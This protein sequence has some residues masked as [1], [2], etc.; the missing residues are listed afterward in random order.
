LGALHHLYQRPHA[1]AQAHVL[2]LWKRTP[3]GIGLGFGLRTHG[4]LRGHRLLQRGTQRGHVSYF[5][6]AL[7]CGF[8]T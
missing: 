8:A 5:K 3:F 2:A 1:L 6:D 4:L 7:R